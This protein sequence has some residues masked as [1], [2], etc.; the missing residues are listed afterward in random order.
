MKWFFILLTPFAPLGM[1]FFYAN[2][3][4]AEAPTLISTSTDLTIANSTTDASSTG[5]GIK[6]TIKATC[7]SSA[8]DT[9]CST[10]PFSVQVL[11]DS[12]VISTFVT[13]DIGNFSTQVAA[14]QYVLQVD[15]ASSTQCTSIGVQVSDNSYQTVNLN[16]TKSGL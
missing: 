15:A 6:G 14:G 4:F 11:Q 5:S 2:N 3:M 1:Y 8:T 9:P 7:A 10:G 13:D 12:E 16:C